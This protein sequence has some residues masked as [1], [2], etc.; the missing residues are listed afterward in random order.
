[1][2]RFLVFSAGYNGALWIK[3][4]MKSIA[5]QSYPNIIHIVVDDASTD[6][7]WK[8]IEKYR[9][10][11]CIAI[12]NKVN[13]GWVENAVRYL[14]EHIVHPEDVVCGVDLD[15]WLAHDRVMEKIA[16]IYR[17]EGVWCTY[18]TPLRNNNERRRNNA[19]GYPADVIKGRSFRRFT[20]WRF[21]AMR[22]FK[23]FLW[24]AM[25]KRRMLDPTGRRYARYTYD[26]A[27]G[28]NLLEMTPPGKLRHVKEEIYI[29]NVSNPLNDKKANRPD[30]YKLGMH[31]KS[32]SPVKNCVK[33]KQRNMNR[34]VVFACGH[35]CAKWVKRHRR[36][37]ELQ[38]YKNFLY[39]AVDDASTDDT[40]KELLRFHNKKR[41]VIIR[42]EKN[43]GWLANAAQYLDKFIE[44]EE[45]VIVVVDMD[46]YLADHWVFDKINNTYNLKDCWITYGT[47]AVPNDPKIKEKYRTKWGVD[48][49]QPKQKDSAEHLRNRTFRKSPAFSHLKTFRAFL[50]RAIDKEDFKGPDGEFAPC[51][52][53]RALMYPMLEMSPTKKIQYM[54]DL[55]YMYNIANP[56]CHAWINREQQLE[57][58]KWFCGKPSYEILK[59]RLTRF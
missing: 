40:Y 59:I 36:S 37:I 46:D 9:H 51:C 13:V 23:A 55:L 35:N 21:W 33:E 24:N 32:M 8:E 57:Y 1:M 20:N 38:T 56:N 25:D 31:F 16:R 34:L 47:W 3:Q 54:K 6:K 42:N 19:L 50:W 49:P 2:L 45:D 4:H 14:A 5:E 53:D 26:W 43:Q 17:K 29:Y 44:S 10:D 28:Y 27:I 22:T 48:K 12:R 41:N 52:Y 58:E 11:R 7:S 18:G 15:D 30:Q 39:V